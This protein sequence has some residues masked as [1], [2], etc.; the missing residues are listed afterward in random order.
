[1]LLAPIG[2]IVFQIWLGQHTG[3]AGVWFRVQREAWDEGASFGWT[4]VKNTA[5]ALTQP[6]TSPTDMITAVSVVATIV[7]L[8]MAWKARL[9][10]VHQ[11][12]LVGDRWRL[13]LLP[14]T[15]TARPRFL[16][17]AFPL[18]I[19][20]AVWFEQRHRTEDARGR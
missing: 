19:G 16:F 12:L 4:A 17:T 8:W 7:L 6:L 2:F 9:P 14:A 10:L 20:A 5:E 15:V 18:L 13:M 3:E 1:M 11:R